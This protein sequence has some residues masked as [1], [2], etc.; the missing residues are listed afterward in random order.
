MEGH[1]AV[2]VE[3]VVLVQPTGIK[4]AQRAVSGRG[5]EY[6]RTEAQSARHARDLA[7]RRFDLIIE[8]RALGLGAPAPSEILNGNSEGFCNF[9]FSRGQHERSTSTFFIVRESAETSSRTS[10]DNAGQPAHY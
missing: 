6:I 5:Q 7:V 3:V 1:A 2:V 10:H 8:R 4:S 9:L